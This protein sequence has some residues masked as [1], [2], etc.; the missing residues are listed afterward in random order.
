MGVD[1]LIGAIRQWNDFASS[2]TPGSVGLLRRAGWPSQWPGSSPPTG[3]S[4][5]PLTSR[6]TSPA[7]SSGWT[8]EAAA[9]ERA[10]RTRSSPLSWL[11][12]ERPV[13]RVGKS[14]DLYYVK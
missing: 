1:W 11:H 3:F 13:T 7:E 5:R 12:E 14:I 9:I 8:I 4:T 6:P 2:E 10:Q